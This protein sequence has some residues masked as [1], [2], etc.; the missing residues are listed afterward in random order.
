MVHGVTTEW[1]DIQVKMGNYKP[2]E[3]EAT[4][5]QIFQ[6]SIEQLEAYDNK[7]IMNS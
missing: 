3:K 7:L 2:L 6:E 5:E 1:D 4:G